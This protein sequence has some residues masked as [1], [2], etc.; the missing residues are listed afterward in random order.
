MGVKFTTY[1]HLGPRVKTSGAIPL[2]PRTTTWGGAEITLQFTCVGTMTVWCVI[3]RRV[4]KMAES[5]Y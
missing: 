3:F 4:C 1:I 5:D 2:F